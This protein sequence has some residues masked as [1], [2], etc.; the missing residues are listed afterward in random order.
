MSFSQRGTSMALALIL[1]AAIAPAAEAGRKTKSRSEDQ[2][3]PRLRLIADP[4]VGFTPVTVVL[5]GQ[6]TGVRRDDPNFCHAAVTWISIPP[7]HSEETASSVREDPVCR[8]PEEQTRVNT[9]FTKSFEL[10]RPGSH[11]FRLIVEGKDHTRVV[12]GYTRVEVLR[13]Q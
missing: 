7:G 4:G 9:S 1:V 5:T 6:L 11:L 8:H 13:V 2:D 10:Y 12:S 3:K